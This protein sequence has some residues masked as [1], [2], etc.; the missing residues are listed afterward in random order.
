[1][2]HSE[3]LIYQRVTIR[4]IWFIIHNIQPIHTYT[5]I[6]ILVGGLED[7]DYDFPIILGMSSSQRGRNHQPDSYDIPVETNLASIRIKPS[8]N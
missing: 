2:F 1:M 4:S 8:E 7:L 3:L 5:Y 6:Y